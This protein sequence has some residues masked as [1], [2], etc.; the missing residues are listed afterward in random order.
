MFFRNLRIYRLPQP[1]SMDLE[2]L[3]EAISH[4]RLAR[5]G[6]MDMISR[7][8]I[9]PRIADG[10]VHSVN[11]HW[12]VILGAEEKILPAGVI[13]REAAERAVKIEADQSRKVGRKELRDI[14]ERV[15]EELM[16]RALTKHRETACWIDPAGGWLAIDTGSDARADELIEALHRAIPD[17]ALRPLQTNISPTSSM[18]DWLVSGEA[19]TGFTIDQDLELRSAADGQ[20]AIRYIRHEL[21]G[22][23]VRDHIADGKIAT[24]LAMTWN[25]RISFVLTERLHVKRLAFLDILKEEAE[26]NAETADEQFDADFTMMTGELSRTL[27]DLVAA[28]G[29][30]MVPE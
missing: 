7:G 3:S 12:L 8:F 22:K 16:P 26:Q 2:T 17:L 1:W 25:D 14:R 9:F 23:G 20:S 15:A 21:E 30:E 24:K 13:R 29:G 11:G 19:P 4:S 5:C 18:T 10:F 28:L 27:S 6:A